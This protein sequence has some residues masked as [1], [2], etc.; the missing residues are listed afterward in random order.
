MI[1]NGINFGGMH[2]YN[3]A[4]PL[5]WDEGKYTGETLD[6]KPHG[7]GVY[8]SSTDLVSYYNGQWRAGEKHGE[9]AITYSDGRTYKGGFKDDNLHGQG[10]EK[11]E[12]GV[13][14][15][16]FK[17]GLA[18]GF[19]TSTFDNGCVQKGQW[20]DGA[21]HDI[22]GLIIL[23]DGSQRRGHWEEGELV[24]YHK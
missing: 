23:D 20:K 24:K 2:I 14:E 17:D 16:N 12:N 19:G 1:N 11:S 4:K 21:F 18:N 7:Q 6:G 8:Q 10:V 5:D 9:G 3:S 15:G 13:H 22:D